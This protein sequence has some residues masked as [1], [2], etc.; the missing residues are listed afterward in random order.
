MDCLLCLG[1]DTGYLRLLTVV[2]RDI[3]GS[4]KQE[5]RN[6]KR[7]AVFLGGDSGLLVREEMCSFCVSGLDC[8]VLIS[9]GGVLLQLN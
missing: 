2:V 9:R 7:Q 6:L 5:L 8:S 4:F 3:R 1:L